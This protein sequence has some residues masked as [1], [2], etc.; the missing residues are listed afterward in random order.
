MLNHQKYS[1]CQRGEY[2]RQ[3]KRW[4]E[5]FKK[6]QFL[7]IQSE[8]FFQKTQETLDQ[9]SRFLGLESEIIHDTR[10]YN[11]GNLETKMTTAERDFLKEYFKPHNDELF[12]LLDQRFNWQ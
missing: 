9:I 7:F 6:D 5:Y 3:I 4:F 1:Y 2:A 11:R 10:I 8:Q 12:K